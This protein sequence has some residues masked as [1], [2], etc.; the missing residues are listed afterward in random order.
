MRDWHLTSTV[1]G[2]VRVRVTSRQRGRC[3]SSSS[4]FGLPLLSSLFLQCCG[5]LL[6]FEVPHEGHC[7]WRVGPELAFEVTLQP[8]VGRA[9]FAGHIP[10]AEG[11]S[12]TR[13]NKRDIGG[14]VRAR[15]LKEEEDS[16]CKGN[17]C[18]M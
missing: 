12:S 10:A 17:V 14:H 11:V 3:S 8:V 7:P 18:V 13:D 6:A 16:A 9:R 2:D 4:E 15:G 5:L 1:C